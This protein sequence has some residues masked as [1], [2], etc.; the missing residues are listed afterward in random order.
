[1]K[2]KFLA[3]VGN[4]EDLIHALL[5]K[6]HS[7]N[8]FAVFKMFVLKYSVETRV[9]EKSI[10]LKSYSEVYDFGSGGGSCKKELTL[11]S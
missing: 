7:T 11:A 4:T 8:P 6:Q 1:M 10:K 5:V 2:M 9:A 3:I